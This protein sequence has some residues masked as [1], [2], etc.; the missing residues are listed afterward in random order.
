MQTEQDQKNTGDTDGS[1][2]REFGLSFQ[3]V[4]SLSTW[5]EVGQ[6]ARKY[7]AERE[8]ILKIIGFNV[9]LAGL[10]LNLG[11][12]DIH[13][14]RVE[15]FFLLVACSLISLFI[16]KSLFS[17]VR[18]KHTELYYAVVLIPVYIGGALIFNIW[19]Y[20]FN[21]FVTELLYYFH[22]VGVPLIAIGVNLAFVAFFK[23]VSRIK[24]IDGRQLKDFFL[25][26]LNLN[27]VIAYTVS[28]FD[29]SKTIERLFSFQFNNLFVLYL[30]F[31]TL[32]SELRPFDGKT[33]KQA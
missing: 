22:I 30:F 32:W 29:F 27:L 3:R 25:L 15:V 24:N 26:S 10:F 11:S 14:K 31:I 18:D 9:A 2:F 28:G 5:K 7:L 6:I 19:K 4:F 23:L 16:L 13:L 21:N 12:N 33:K 1:L 8:D 17:L 20:L